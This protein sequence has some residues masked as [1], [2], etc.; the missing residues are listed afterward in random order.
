MSDPHIPMNLLKCTDA[1]MIPLTGLI[2]NIVNDCLWSVQLG[3]SSITPA[4]KKSSRTDKG[5]YRPISVLPSVSKIFEKL[6]H[7]QLS[8]Y[9]EDKLSPLLCGFR[10]KYS[11]QH[12]LLHMTERWRHCLDNSGAIAA[13]LMDLSKA[14]DCI[15]YDLLPRLRNHNATD[16][17]NVDFRSFEAWKV[18][19][20]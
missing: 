15:P 7:D 13:V 9:M 18:N 17:G 19:V 4:H 6:L 16:D 14:Y 8:K 10:K 1:C 3:S 5:N 2:N 11:T 20:K 12:T